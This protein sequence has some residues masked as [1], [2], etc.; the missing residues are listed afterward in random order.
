MNSQLKDERYTKRYGDGPF[1]TPYFNQYLRPSTPSEKIIPIEETTTSEDTFATTIT[2]D[3]EGSAAGILFLDESVYTSIRDMAMDPAERENMVL[4]RAFLGKIEDLRLLTLRGDTLDVCD[5]YVVDMVFSLQGLSGVVDVNLCVE[6]GKRDN[7]VSRSELTA[8][9][10]WTL[11][12]HS[13]DEAYREVRAEMGLVETRIRR[14]LV[15]LSAV[16]HING[17]ELTL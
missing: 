17:L 10:K 12:Y 5:S 15:L 6:F 16:A 11:L 2:F 9:L 14:S 1:L 13:D 4:G 8:W 7:N 3:R